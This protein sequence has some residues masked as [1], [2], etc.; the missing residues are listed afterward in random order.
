[1]PTPII[2]VKFAILSEDLIDEER[3]QLLSKG[4]KF[5]VGEGTC[6]QLDAL[7]LQK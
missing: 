5:D 3:R 4:F 6:V 1:V 7:P 2:V